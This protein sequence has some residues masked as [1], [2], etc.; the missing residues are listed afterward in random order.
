M[1]RPTKCTPEVIEAVLAAVRKGHY[2]ET[3][4]RLARISDQTFYTWKERGKAG[5]EPY[6][7][8]LDALKTAE[9]DAQED[10]LGTVRAGASGSEAVNWTSAMTFME[11]R[12]PSLYGKR[13]P[14][15]QEI[16]ELEKRLKQAELE[17]AEAKLAL[18][19]AGHDPDTATIVVNIPEA[20]K[21]G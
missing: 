21:R 8:F 10:Y 9:A 20:L 14:H 4:T 11:R 17:T 18:L 3:A 5:E 12:W 19:K 16:A 7:S 1:A 13:D 15:R 6:A 2:I